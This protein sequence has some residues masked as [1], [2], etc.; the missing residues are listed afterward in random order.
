MKAP[1]PTISLV[2][3][4]LNRAEWLPA[5]LDSVLEQGYP[6]LEY[7]VADGGSTDGSVEAIR[8]RAERLAGWVSQPDEGQYDAINRGFAGSTGE[9]MGW[10]NSDDLH[11]PWTLSVV[12]SVFAALPEVEWLTTLHPLIWN[13]AGEAVRCYTLPG[14]SRRAFMRGDNIPGAGRW[15]AG[16]IQQEST[17]WRR[18]LWERAGGRLDASLDLA[19]DFDLWARFF[20]HAPLHG[21]AAPLAGFRVHGDQ[22]TAQMDAYVRQAR[23]VLERHGGRVAPAGEGFLRAKFRPALRGGPLRAAAATRLA[24]PRPLCVYSPERAGWTV[25]SR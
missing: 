12:G 25:V 2:T 19:A 14:F 8:A 22:K 16:W 3:P 6:A 23:A 18:S 10:L 11:T 4:T 20:E 17:F 9:V 21:V 15:A 5:T 24:S 1:A 7:F 13:D